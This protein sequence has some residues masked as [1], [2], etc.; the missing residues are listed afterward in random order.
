MGSDSRQNA[1]SLV[2]VD[3]IDSIETRPQQARRRYV[4][5]LEILVVRQLK[6]RYRGSVLGVYWSLLNPV[7]MTVIYTAIFGH[8]LKS[9][10]GDNLV[11]Y[12]IAVFTGLITINVFSGATAQA[13]MS[14]VG[15]GSLLTKI[16]LP[17]SIFPLSVVSAYLVQFAVGSLPLLII[18]TIITSRSALNTCALILP[19]TALALL[20]IG[21]SLLVS[22]LYVFFRDLP[23][24]Y[25]LVVFMLW[26]TSPIFYPEAIVPQNV[27]VFLAFN[28]VAQI[29]TSMRQIALSGE[30]PDVLRIAAA[31]ASGIIVLAIGA[32][33]FRSLRYRFAE[34][35]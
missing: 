22:A 10:Y 9:Y 21:T 19:I 16:R 13:L 31:L 12:A 27:R 20:C 1:L 11:N 2:M 28:P 23:Y 4:E 35:L 5:L 15:G 33:A 30:P 6:A 26:I 34:S 17:V 32:I 14:I 3:Y 7:I 24:F 29:V 25:E 8:Q 18:L